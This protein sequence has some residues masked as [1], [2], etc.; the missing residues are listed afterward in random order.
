VLGICFAIAFVTGL[1]SHYA[2]NA[3]HPVA[4]PTSPS[5]GYRLTQGLHVA[6]GT[7]SI[8]LLLVK[9]WVVY[10]RLFAAPPRRLGALLV[11]A[12]E[13]AS[14]GVLVAASLFEVAIGAMNSAQLYRWSFDF[15]P[16]HYA[17]AFVVIGALLVHIAVKLPVIREALGA[18]VDDTAQD[19]AAAR[20]PGAFGRR[21]LLRTTWLAGGVAVVTTSTIGGTLPV[22]NRVAGLSARSRRSGIPI[23]HSAAEAQVT[24]TATSGGYRCR[25]VVAGHTTELARADLLA[26]PQATHVLPIA[27]VEGWSADGEW[28]GVPLRALLD[29]LGAPRGRDVAVT[30]LEQAVTAESRTVL[31]ADF[32]DD[33]RTLLALRLDG[34]DLAID[35]G[36]PVRLIAPDRPGVY[37]TKWIAKLEVQA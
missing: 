17:V 31:P 36:Y 37:Q 2:Q 23:N 7:A 10:P 34:E 9:L 29:S 35:H 30:S 32:V 18:D 12:L 22:V 19:R 3:T 15:R 5:W 4:F 20:A 8:P 6:A 1:I 11:T 28:S 16:V 33:D 13:R 26:M 24:A 21:A 14:I 27:C 25:V